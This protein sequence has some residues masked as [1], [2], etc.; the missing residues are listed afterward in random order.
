MGLEHLSPVWKSRV[1]LIHHPIHLLTQTFSL[2]IIRHLTSSFATSRTATGATIN[3]NV[4]RNNVLQQMTYV[5]IFSGRTGC[6]TV[7]FSTHLSFF[8]WNDNWFISCVS[9]FDCFF[10]SDG[11]MSRQEL[12]SIFSQLKKKLNWHLT[13]FL[14]QIKSFSST[15]LPCLWPDYKLNGQCPFFREEKNH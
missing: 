12:N 9:M 7:H 11:W 6:A 13:I 15:L 4:G 2:F 8:F 3:V 10:S 1:W 14:S 5:V